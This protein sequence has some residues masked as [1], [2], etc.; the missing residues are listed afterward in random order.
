MLRPFCFAVCYLAEQALLR[1]GRAPAAFA[2]ASDMYLPAL[3][4]P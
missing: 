2:S 3:V 1:S 4:V